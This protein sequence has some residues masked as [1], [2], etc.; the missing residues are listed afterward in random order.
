MKTALKVDLL[1][2]A[3]VLLYFLVVLSAIN[4]WATG[5]KHNKK[6]CG[7]TPFKTDILKFEKSDACY[8]VELEVSFEQ[9]VTF[10]LSHVNFD[11][12]CGVIT[13]EWNSEGWKM[14][15]NHI[16]PTTGVGG[17]K[18][19]DIT[20]FGKDQNIKNFQVSF[21]FCPDENCTDQKLFTTPKV[22]YKAGQCVYYVEPENRHCNNDSDDEKSDDGSDEVAE[23]TGSNSGSSGDPVD[24]GSPESPN[25]GS[26]INPSSFSVSINKVDPTCF[27]GNDGKI[28]L[29]INGGTE[30]YDISW[31]TNDI[32]SSISNLSAGTYSYTIL[33]AAGD[34]L[35][36]EVSLSNPPE[37]IVEP[38]LTKPI[39]NGYNNGS[40]NLN[41]SGGTEPYTFE[42][43]DGSLDQ[44]LN[45]LYA[46]TY[47]VT[48]T[49]S[50]GCST[51]KIIPLFNETTI[52]DNADIVQP[53]CQLSTAGSISLSPT[54]GTEPYS[55][56]WSG[57]EQSN[58]LDGLSDGNYSVK[59]TD[60]NGCTAT[61]AYPIMTDQGIE[62]FPSITK[63]NCFN[64]PIGEID[65]T[66]SGGT[67][68][69]TIEWSNGETTEDIKGLTAGN[70]TATIKDALG[71]QITHH[72]SILQNDIIVG[73]EGITIPSC[74]GSDDG[75]IAISISNGTAPY[76]IKWS[77]GSTDEDISNLSAG[78]YSV[79][80]SDALGCI[81]EKSF[82]L[83]EP[84]PVQ[85]TYEGIV[86][87]CDGSQKII[88]NATGGSLEYSYLWSDGNTSAELNNPTTGTYVVAVTDTRACTVSEEIIVEDPQIEA[89]T[90]LISDLTADIL[91]SSTNNIL[92]SSISGAISYSWAV[93]SSDGSWEITSAT[94]QG[95]IAF[96]AG[97]AGTNATFT[98]SV[99]YE[100]GCEITCEKMIEV[101]TGT[102]NPV[103]NT[104]EDPVAEE[105]T[106]DSTDGSGEVSTDASEDDSDNSACDDSSDDI[107][108]DENAESNSDDGSGGDNESEQSDEDDYTNH[109]NQWDKEKECDECFY[110]NP[111]VIT[112]TNQGYMYEIEVNGIECRYDL[113]HLTVEIPECYE[114]VSYSNSMNWK[115]EKVQSD[116]TTGLTGIKVDDIP[117]F[118][119]DAHNSSFTVKLELTADDPACYDELKCFAPVIAYKA[120]TCVYEEITQS[121]CAI[122]EEF[123]SHEIST[124][125]NPTCDY[126]KVNMENCDKSSSYTAN[127]FDF[128]GEKL[129][130]YNIDKGFTDEFLVDLRYKK[131]GLYLL[132]LTSSKGRSTMHRIVKQ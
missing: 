26:E 91:C 15:T 86:N 98:L 81:T 49:D 83:P 54:G 43:K 87:E 41:V 72:A 19:D 107:P 44:N 63:T 119:K 46:G 106:G 7:D 129:C 122:D 117:S 130:T 123:T 125:P 116:P 101:C 8:L 42:W 120:S 73:Y 69:Y 21:T 105:G 50:K 35:S 36:G 16:D 121:E 76:I 30:P 126:I 65:L 97:N 111:I 66:V 112:K 31:N 34:Q 52:F 59:I 113:S 84:D 1:K 89:M 115:M 40:I 61:A 104:E 110:T 58:A 85:I 6:G 57:G 127:L 131:H 118:G 68:P 24:S 53:S 77:N 20:N 64:D 5:G 60:Q 12:G 62:A 92:N 80:V 29:S 25:D 56:A 90:C 32:T 4:A 79:Q 96:S 100:G 99:S 23:D 74:N 45:N 48:V 22:A 28:S 11:F 13:N 39:C 128:D 109:D 88:I 124:Y 82:T 14:E 9:Q 27:D 78:T 108:N 37:I 93:T 3:F 33:D 114:L 70:Y 75:A 132:Q 17:I 47:T 10:E 51:M 103:E 94:N 18:I 67:E 71:C 102:D 95:Q 38:I 2:T 55:Y